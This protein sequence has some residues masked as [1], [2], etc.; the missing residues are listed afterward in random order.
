MDNG[1]H[2][3][4]DPK[5]AEHKRKSRENQALFVNC[6]IGLLISVN[7]KTIGI[8]CP[9]KIYKEGSPQ[10]FQIVQIDNFKIKNRKV[11]SIEEAKIIKNI[12]NEVVKEL[13]PEQKKRSYCQPGKAGFVRYNWIYPFLTKESFYKFGRDVCELIKEKLVHSTSNQIV[14]IDNEMVRVINE[15]VDSE[16]R[17]LKSTETRGQ[18]STQN[19]IPENEKTESDNTET[20]SEDFGSK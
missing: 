17:K 11:R 9:L 4:H 8:K 20:I 6:L 13:S 2:K 1:S 10:Y 3:V 5:N 7:K 19:D 14:F 15:W 12:T 16:K 18:L